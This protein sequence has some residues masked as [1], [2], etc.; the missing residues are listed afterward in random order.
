MKNP[1]ISESGILEWPSPVTVSEL[2]DAL[3]L[4][5]EEIKLIFLNGVH[6]RM[7]SM[8]NDGDRIGLFPPIGGG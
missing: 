5:R 4:P 8:V 6:A 3:A 7:D 2:V 1:L